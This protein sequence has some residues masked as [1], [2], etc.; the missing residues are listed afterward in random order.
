MPSACRRARTRWS[1]L[2]HWL[3][4]SDRWP[5][6]H[7]GPSRVISRSGVSGT[8][9]GSAPVASATAFDEIYLQPSGTLGLTGLRSERMYMRGALDKLEG[10]TSRHGPAFYGLP[11]NTDT[12]T[13]T[14]S[15]T[16]TTFPTKIDAGDHTV[17][18]F[19]PGFPVYWDVS[20]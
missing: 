3:K 8:V 15:D 5:S 17:T 11:E 4:I 16:A 10:F 1:R 12:I 13:L 2:G 19:D 20:A 7:A 18:V 14:K 6:A 9:Q